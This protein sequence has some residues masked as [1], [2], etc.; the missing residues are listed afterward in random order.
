MTSY[1][2]MDLLA[3]SLSNLFSCSLTGTTIKNAQKIELDY[4]LS[5]AY[6]ESEG[7][8]GQKEG[9]MLVNG[10][11]EGYV[12]ELVSRIPCGLE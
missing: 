11:G 6:G 3:P 10:L 1:T 4:S 2:F 9:V 7:E 12:D 8:G 5:T